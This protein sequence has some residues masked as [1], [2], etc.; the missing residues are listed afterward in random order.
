MCDCLDGDRSVLLGF[1]ALVIRSNAL[2]MPDRMM[3]RLDKGPRQILVAVLAVAF[4]L[5]AEVAEP[6]A[7]HTTCI[8]SK[9]PDFRKTLDG[10]GLIQDGHPENLSNPVSAQ[11][12]FKAGLQVRLRQD[13]VLQNPDA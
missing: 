11:E 3:R 4:A 13:R 1:L 9:L 5:F 6:F 2:V 10:P 12:L 7:A 8:R